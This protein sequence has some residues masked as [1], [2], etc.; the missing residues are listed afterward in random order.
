MQCDIKQLCWIAI[1]ASTA[2]VLS[3]VGHTTE[4]FWLFSS[5]LQGQNIYRHNAVLCVCFSLLIGWIIPFEQTK[6]TSLTF[7]EQILLPSELLCAVLCMSLYLKSGFRH[8]WLTLTITSLSCDTD[9]T[10]AAPPSCE[11]MAEMNRSESAMWQANA[12][13]APTEREIA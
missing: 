8:Y 6:M 4:E 10:K 2:T 7:A 13:L 11:Q 3:T 12:Q 5:R 1:N 9:P